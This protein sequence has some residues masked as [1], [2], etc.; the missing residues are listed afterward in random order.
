MCCASDEA[1]KQHCML[2]IDY[3]RSH[4]MTSLSTAFEIVDE[5][6]SL[7]PFIFS[8]YYSADEHT[9]LLELLEAPYLSIVSQI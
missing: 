3:Y 5:L 2:S 4:R 7:H 8:D 6:Y 9:L 1:D